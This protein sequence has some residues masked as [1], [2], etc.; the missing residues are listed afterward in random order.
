[1]LQ[2]VAVCRIVLQCIAVCCSQSMAGSAVSFSRV[3]VCCKQV[4]MPFARCCNGSTHCN[5]LQHPAPVDHSQHNSQT[6]LQHA[7]HHCNTLP[8][9]TIHNTP[10]QTWM[11]RICL[12][13][14]RAP[15]SH[16]GVHELATAMPSQTSCSINRSLFI[17][18]YVSF[19]IY[20]GLFSYNPHEE[21]N[22]S[23]F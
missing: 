2:C 20:T 21:G 17:Y 15:T 14:R 16:T 5:T 18:K 12:S 6:P 19:H 13:Y 3:L 1:M 11:H 9:S 22:R 7:A 8:M 10:A 4:G 23:A